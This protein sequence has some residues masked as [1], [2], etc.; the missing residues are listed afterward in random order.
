MIHTT[1]QTGDQVAGHEDFGEFVIVTVSDPT[2]WSNLDGQSSSRKFDGSGDG[3]LLE[4]F[5]V[6]QVEVGGR[7]KSRGFLGLGAAKTGSSPSAAAAG[8]AG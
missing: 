1:E 6:F 2:R 3:V 7:S 5:P 4:T 8:A